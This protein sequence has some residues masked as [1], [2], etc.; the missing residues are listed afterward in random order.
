MDSTLRAEGR[1]ITYFY[2]GSDWGPGMFTL[3][4]MVQTDLEARWQ[5]RRLD[6]VCFFHWDAE[7]LASNFF[8]PRA[9]QLHLISWEWD[10]GVS[11]VFTRLGARG[12]WKL[13]SWYC[14]PG[15][16]LIAF[17][18]AGAVHT[19][20]FRQPQTSLIQSKKKKKKI[21]S[22]GCTHAETWEG[23]EETGYPQSPSQPFPSAY[24]PQSCQTKRLCRH[25]LRPPI[26]GALLPLFALPV[27]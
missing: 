10:W 9:S 11:F 13:S 19:E 18:R 25:V 8:F 27:M 15:S 14:S 7:S 5:G 4:A 1:P 23:K 2:G 22:E 24:H 21:L 17:Y 16:N 3:V 26:S 12:S 6:R 20:L